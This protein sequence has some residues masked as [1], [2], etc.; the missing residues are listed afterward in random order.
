MKK[1]SFRSVLMTLLIAASLSSYLFLQSIEI[2]E[3]DIQAIE[4]Y[5]EE[6]E[7]AAFPE[8]ELMKKVL[9]ITKTIIPT[10]PSE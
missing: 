4:S 6:Q 8:I 3:A 1:V 5:E 10:I 2:S 7:K 9:K